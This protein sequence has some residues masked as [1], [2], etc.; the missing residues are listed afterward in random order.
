[1]NICSVG[2]GACAMAVHD[3]HWRLY[4]SCM[5]EIITETRGAVSFRAA[6]ALILYSAELK[7]VLKN[8]VFRSRLRHAQNFIPQAAYSQNKILSITQRSQ[9]DQVSEDFESFSW[10]TRQFFKVALNY[11]S[12]RLMVR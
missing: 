11:S 12:C 9:N 10:A 2:S 8:K 5:L 7:G 3:F 4:H 1:M 6:P